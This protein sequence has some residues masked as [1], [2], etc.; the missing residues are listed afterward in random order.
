MAEV[1]RLDYER[2]AME[3]KDI[4][5][6]LELPDQLMFLILKNLY[7]QYY[8]GQISKE[9]AMEEKTKARR[10]RDEDLQLIGKYHET[11]SRLTK[12]FA[13]VDK[14]SSA[15]SQKR[16]LENADKIYFALYNEKPEELR[17]LEEAENCVQQSLFRTIT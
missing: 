15:Y 4:P 16:T 13:E 14:A 7:K 5:D 12:M 10:K 8:D 9:T 6:G 1:I 17:K 11:Y 2:E 3:G